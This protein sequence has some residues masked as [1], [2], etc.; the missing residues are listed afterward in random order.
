M[1]LPEI[2]MSKPKQSTRRLALASLVAAGLAGFA[3]S[4]PATAFDWLSQAHGQAAPLAGADE[5]I[6]SPPLDMG[7]LRGR[8]VLVDFWTYSCINCLRTL[9][10][11]KAWADKYRDAGLVVIGVHTPEFDFEKMPANVRQAVKDLGISYPVAVDSNY[12]V[13]NAWRNQAWPAMYFVDAR[14]QVRHQQYGEGNYEDLER[15]IQSLLR[16]RGASSVPGGFVTPAGPGVQ[17]AGG[18]ASVRT[19]ETYVG[20]A[21]AEGAAHRLVPDQTQS[22][23][24]PGDLPFNQWALGGS[25]QVGRERAVAAA[26]GGR[27]AYHFGARDLHM[28]LGPGDKPVRFRVLLDGRPPGADHGTDTDAQGYGTVDRLKLYQMV[29]QSSTNRDRVF[30]IEFLDP[31]VQAFAFTFG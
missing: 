11:V 28:V 19:P 3:A 14:G 21:Q 17:A 2:I 23:A 13:W 31:G 9:P 18:A 26:A 6:G 29:R 4:R 8:V 24:L 15:R 12:K 5:W 27:V 30:E 1:S 20:Y 7:A 25:W 22:Y 16:E 10:Y